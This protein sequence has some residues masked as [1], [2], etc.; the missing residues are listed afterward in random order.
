MQGAYM[1][2]WK[3]ERYGP[4]EVLVQC[5]MPRPEPREDEI[6]I[7]VEARPVTVADCRIRGFRVP[8]SYRL[9]ARIA[10]G[11]T[12]PRKAVLGNYFAG[13]VAA[14]GRKVSRFAVGDR[15]FGGTDRAFGTYAEYVCLRDS[16]PMQKI[17][18]DLDFDEAAAS[19]WGAGTA[20][21]FL[22]RAEIQPGMNILINGA[23]GSIGLASVQLA[24]YFGLHVTGVCSGKNR[25]LVLSVGADV[26]IDYNRDNFT[27][28]EDT[29]DLVLDTVGNHSPGELCRCI[30]PGGTLLPVI[31]TPAVRREA[32][33]HTRAKTIRFL[34][35]DTSVNQKLLDVIA[36]RLERKE[37]RPIIDSRYS[38]D[39][40]PEAHAR[41]DTGRKTGD[42]IVLGP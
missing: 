1:N 3:C 13:T 19:P 37:L 42:V 30:R 5:E 27:E 28:E 36:E 23:S 32:L 39:Q 31:A 35:G 34:G 24:K 15:V 14:T 40:M 10:L 11:F 12:K 38:F 26:I 16:C 18:G 6:L 33:R 8:P 22:Q 21:F 25:D 4:P 9:L 20:L 29:Y 17:P 41:V 7:K 2:A